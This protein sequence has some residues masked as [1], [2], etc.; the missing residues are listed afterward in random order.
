MARIGGCRI[1]GLCEYSHD[2]IETKEAESRGEGA[3]SRG[4]TAESRGEGA[5]SRGEG[6]ESRGEGAVEFCVDVEYESL[7]PSTALTLSVS[8]LTHSTALTL[9]LS[10]DVES[11]AHDISTCVEEALDLYNC[12]T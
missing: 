11:H 2:E 12:G 1:K 4:E 3:E 6:A 9:T 5:K 10:V 8:H 7:D